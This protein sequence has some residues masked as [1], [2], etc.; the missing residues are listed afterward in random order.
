M[1]KIYSSEYVSKGHPD[2]LAD[3]ISDSVLDECLKINPGSHVACETLISKDLVVV[4]GEI[5]TPISDK[6]CRNIIK[7]SS[8]FCGYNRDQSGFYFDKAKIVINLNGQSKD[9]NYAVENSYEKRNQTSKTD[10]ADTL[11]AG[12]QG[13]VVGYACNETPELMPLPYIISRDLINQFEKLHDDQTLDYLRPVAKSLVAIVY[14]NNKPKHIDRLVLSVQHTKETSEEKL[15]I[16]LKEYVISQNKYSHLF[17]ANTKILINPSGC[18]SI[19]GPEADAGLTGRKIIV[20][21]YG[22]RARHGGGAFSGKDASK[23]DRSGAYLCRWIAKNIV[24]L[25][26]ADQC[27]IELLYAIGV[28]KPI[29]IDINC[30]GTHKVNMDKIYKFVEDNFDLRIYSTIKELDLKK[31]IYK[32]TTILGHFGHQNHFAWEKLKS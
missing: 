29:G 26:Y 8:D 24:G 13:I 23:S 28:S 7:N 2:K 19:G 22:G 12:D 4:S 31:P 16:D 11:G 15:K 9:I 32:E 30:F 5:N 18:F 27:E 17:N 10:N 14:E 6:I 20:D 21:T 3:L 25:S 1:D